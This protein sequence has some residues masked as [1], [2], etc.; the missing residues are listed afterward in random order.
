MSDHHDDW[1]KH[2]PTEPDA[3][4]AHGDTNPVMIISFL[5]VVIAVTFAL[6]IIF[7]GFFGRTVASEQVGKSELRTPDD[8]YLEAK[9]TWNADLYGEADWTDR[10]NGVV[11]IP[12]DLAKSKVIDAYANASRE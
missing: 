1:F 4:E 2:D 12:Y 7:L 8:E 6:I 5:I 9:A 3:Q 11:R 10:E